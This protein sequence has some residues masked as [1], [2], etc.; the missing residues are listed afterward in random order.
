MD[1]LKGI[2]RGVSVPYGR[3]DGVKLD[4]PTAGAAAEG[5]AQGFVRQE[6]GGGQAQKDLQE[7]SQRRPEEEQTL[8]ETL[9]F[10]HQSDRTTRQKTWGMEAEQSVWQKVY[11]EQSAQNANRT[12]GEKQ[13]DQEAQ[14]EKYIGHK[15]PRPVRTRCKRHNGSAVN[16]KDEHMN[17]KNQEEKVNEQKA[18]WETWLMQKEA[19]EKRKEQQENKNNIIER[20]REQAEAIKKAYDPKKR[21]NLYDATRDL[22]LLAQIEKI[23]MLKAMQSRLMIQVRYV[24]QSGA[25][26][27]EIRCAVNKL[28]K[29]IG[30]A[31]A[32][33]KGLEKEAL[34]EKKRKRAIEAKRRAKELAL[35][36]EIAWRKKARKARE[37]KDIEESKMGMGANYGG[38]TGD[39]ALDMAL[40][41]FAS[42]DSGAATL[43]VGAIVDVAVA[44]VGAAAADAGGGGGMDISV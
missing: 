31:K 13:A 27:S 30:K 2:A 1:G 41:A 3:N 42:M 20:L 18:A 35:Q 21:K 19:A 32:K 40:E 11:E 23:P 29:V 43:D 38:P 14:R 5:A 6:T 22:T 16:L 26:S 9:Q 39:P 36:R 25:E 17:P 4:V 10:M 33:V 7:R 34:L 8:Q 37:Q 24:K 28:K 15:A 12:V 44:N